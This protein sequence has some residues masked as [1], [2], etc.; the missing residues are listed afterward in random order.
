MVSHCTAPT[1][2]PKSCMI[3]VKATLR[4]V[5]SE[6]GVLPFS[7]R[8]SVAGEMPA[9]SDT[10]RA[11]NPCSLRHAARPSPTRACARRVFAGVG[12]TTR[13][14]FSASI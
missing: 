3:G 5:S 8:L 4:K 7:N 1:S 11:V 10:C 9:R 12:L 13:P 6:T 14:R 2:I